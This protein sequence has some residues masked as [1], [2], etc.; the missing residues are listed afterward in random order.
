MYQNKSFSLK[1]C[2]HKSSSKKKWANKKIVIKKNESRY[3]FE[4]KIYAKLKVKIS[5][6]AKIWFLTRKK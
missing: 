1:N 2:Q 4:Q 6:Y 5:K 3:K